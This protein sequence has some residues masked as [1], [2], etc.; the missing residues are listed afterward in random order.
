MNHLY[1]DLAEVYEAMYQTFINY[2][3]EFDTYSKIL[4]ENG[5]RRILELGCGTGNL[6]KYFQEEGFKY[7]GIDL[8]SQMIRMAQKKN[9]MCSFSVGDMR[10]FRL[11]EQVS[12]TIMTG[13]TI[14]YLI[15]NHDLNAT[16]R[17]IWT[18][19]EPGGLFCFDFIDATQFIPVIAPIKTIR[20]QAHYQDTDYVRDSTWSVVLDNGMDFNWASIYYK[21]VGGELKEIGKDDSVI[22]AFTQNEIDILLQINN[23]KVLEFFPRDSYAF[24]TYVAIAEKLAL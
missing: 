19:M 24:P 12:G 20:H 22:R 11:Q 9:P 7:Q 3:D 14:S 23:F 6:S 17:S 13:R 8:S 1:A 18:N 10:N 16:F 2:Q 5:K 21:R 4:R 15:S